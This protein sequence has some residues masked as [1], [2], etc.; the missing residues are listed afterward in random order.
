MT[1]KFPMAPKV[2][3]SMVDVRD[4]AV[5][6]VR[7]IESGVNGTRY[8]TNS[9]PS[10]YFFIELAKPLSEEFK[11]T[12][13]KIPT[14]EAGDCLFKCM[15]LFDKRL[16]PLVPVY[17]MKFEIDDQKTRDHLKIQYRPLSESVVQMAHNL[18]DLKYMEDHRKN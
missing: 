1:G 9:R 14:S 6:H 3:L 16:K 18:I 17:G 7:A 2:S 12:K 11:G 15:G 10:S 4:I 8:M 13:Y 5:I